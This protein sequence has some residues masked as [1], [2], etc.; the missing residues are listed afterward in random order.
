LQ[1]LV[2]GGYEQ[3]TEGKAARNRGLDTPSQPSSG[4]QKHRVMKLQS[5]HRHEV[6]YGTQFRASILAGDA[7]LCFAAVLILLPHSKACTV[8]RRDRELASGH[9][10]R[11]NMRA[12]SSASKEGTIMATTKSTSG[13]QKA[14]KPP[15]DDA[16]AQERFRCIARAA[17]F[18][19]EARGFAPGR[20][21]EDWLEA[22][23]E[24][25]AASAQVRARVG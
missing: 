22:E 7:V 25:D 3:G 19:A 17:Y 10:R 6:K 23:K 1:S 14:Q 24:Y 21:L 8:E 20:E 2:P 13:Q 9:V 16:G 12:A 15:S 4:G 5:G 18:K 11:R